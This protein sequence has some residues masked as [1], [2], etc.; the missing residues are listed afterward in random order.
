VTVTLSSEAGGPA[1]QAGAWD[2][3]QPKTEA[4]R[5][6]ISLSGGGIR[7]AAFSLGVYQHLAEKGIFSRARFLSAVSGGCYIAGG[8]AIA[9]AMAE[10]DTRGSKPPPWWRGSPEEARLRRNLS[11]LAPGGHGRLWLA[12][13]ILYGLVLNLTPLVLGAF[14]CGRLC[15]LLYQWLYPGL[16]RGGHVD[17]SAA[18]TIL[19]LA[20]A[21]VGVAILAVGVW[22]FRD[23]DRS[24]AGLSSDSA[25]QRLVTA[26][27]ILSMLL[28]TL[29][30]VVPLAVD[31]IA[32][33]L[34]ATGGSGLGPRAYGWHSAR[35]LVGIG[36]EAVATVT[37]LVAVWLLTRG[38]LRIVR[39]ILAAASGIAI[40]A[41][42][43]VLA[44]GTGAAHP[45]TLTGET[46]VVA[47]ACAFIAFFAVFAHNRRYS[48]HL[49]YRERIQDAFATRRTTTVADDG[50][51]RVVTQAIPYDE[52]IHLSDV[53]ATNAQLT[54]TAEPFPELVVCAAVA[55]RGA[56]VPSKTRAASF[57]FEGEY[58]GN[59][60]IRVH[61][62]TSDV[63]AGDWIGGGDLTLPSM[64]A[65]SGAALSPL[66]GRFTLPTFRF[67]IALMNIR[68]GVWIRNP[69]R[70][71]PTAAPSGLGRRAF[72]YI[73]RGW[74][75]PGAWYVLKEGL[76]LADI[77]GRYLYVS[78]GG[79]WENLGLTELLRRRC[80]HIIAVDASGNAGLAD[81]AHAMAVA[82]A[83]LGVEV[84]LDPGLA[85]PTTDR[86]ASKP[87]V[88][89][90]FQYPDGQKGEIYLARC[91][92]W[93]GA[94]PDLK[95]LALDDRA[96]PNH[97]TT[98]QFL[99]G[100][101]FD[102]YRALG[103]AAGE[104]LS[105]ELRLPPPQFDEPRGEPREP[106]EQNGRG[107]LSARAM[108]E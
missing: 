98:N 15:G 42:P 9:H 33:V 81:L 24:R 22:R 32:H 78:D 28:V 27:L 100:D 53:A 77:H 82:R 31:G 10:P 60:R 46:G 102:A 71:A 39:G 5:L 101:L 17:L 51:T 57:T 8:L 87:V 40:L 61:A 89:G 85:V 37:G 63:E 91:V 75:E 56:D 49:F 41:I 45:W 59:S 54:K 25:S 68:L 14:V 80:T 48:M 106:S 20:A 90:S 64:M 103:S 67:L 84:R 26:A 79:H 13:N 35:V 93:D 58:C 66:M 3:D 108:R 76:G 2:Y 29:G 88:V 50:S 11:Y 96:F 92:L 4:T 95:L 62:P 55:A 21:C 1:A 94:P 69:N 107:V 36:A 7:S 73:K 83:E 34:T 52:A 86:I 23:K 6:G 12:A 19:T 16:A 104:V 30:V 70:Q 105:A 47:L 65:I 44:A 74:Q 43:F 97:P 99:S 72:R 38:R 18:L